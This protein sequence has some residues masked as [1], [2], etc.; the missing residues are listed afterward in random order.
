MPLVYLFIFTLSCLQRPPPFLLTILSPF[1]PTSVYAVL[2][3]QYS[4]PTLYIPFFSSVTINLNHS[5]FQ[6]FIFTLIFI[7]YSPLPFHPFLFSSSSSPI[8]SSSTL[9][10]FP[11]YSLSSYPCL[12]FFLFYSFYTHVLFLFSHH[13]NTG[14][15]H[16][17]SVRV[18]V[19]L[20]ICSVLFR[21][22]TY[23]VLGFYFRESETYK[24]VV[25][26]SLADPWTTLVPFSSF[27]ILSF[28]IL[29]SVLLRNTLLGFYFRESETY[30]RDVSGRWAA[31]QATLVPF[32]FLHSSLFNFA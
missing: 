21:P 25:S 9:F 18:C 20:Q 30:E 1:Y 11:I 22:D 2:F 29:L 17:T 14:G 4:F 13:Y 3:Q 12:Q 15:W 26:G 28:S 5:I 7:Y 8:F 31:P 23:N 10:P 27:L 24:G 6:S 19:T 32:F 16:P